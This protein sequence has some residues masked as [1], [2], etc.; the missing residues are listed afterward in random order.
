[1]KKGFYFLT[2]LIVIL[3]I[4]LFAFSQPS[5]SVN[6]SPAPASTP[7]TV[8]FKYLLELQEKQHEQQLL[9][10]K[11]IADRAMQ[12]MSQQAQTVL[13][14]VEIGGFLIVFASTAVGWWV[15]R[16]VRHFQK[17]SKQSEQ[18]LSNMEKNLTEI[19]GAHSKFNLRIEAMTTLITPLESQVQDVSL[20]VEK[21][22]ESIEDIKLNERVSGIGFRLRSGRLEDKWRAAHTASEIARGNRGAI[23]IPLLLECLSAQ[24]ADPSIVME[25]LY[26]L[27]SRAKDLI[28]DA[29]AIGLILTASRSPEKAVR[30]QALETIGK[31]GLDAPAL[32]QRMESC[33]EHDVDDEV[34]KLAGRILSDNKPT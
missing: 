13:V 28:G 24:D 5:P 34:R 7:E 26:G 12:V 11:E 33:C 14:I 18:V 4:P 19:E 31:I 25:A 1:M 21:I 22:Q 10:Q 32:R 30:M 6:A 3:S 27:S 9:V 16:Q 2:L 8:T 20:D 15:T 29:D 23:V 17:L